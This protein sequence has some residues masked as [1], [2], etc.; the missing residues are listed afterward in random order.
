MD[1][2]QGFG[3]ESQRGYSLRNN[4]AQSEATG[5]EA[6]P[7]APDITHVLQGEEN[8]GHGRG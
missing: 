1:T 7:L 5:K 3:G 6:I 8:S 4:S 2:R